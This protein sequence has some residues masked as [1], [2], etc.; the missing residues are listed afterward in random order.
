MTTL[1]TLPCVKSILSKTSA[2]V[3]FKE[4]IPQDEHFQYLTSLFSTS[5]FLS[6]HSYSV[7][8]PFVEYH[9][10]T[11]RRVVIPRLKAE[12]LS[13]DEVGREARETRM[14]CH[15]PHRRAG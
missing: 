6:N 11:A 8:C 4:R 3:N 7:P 2:A 9:V 13:D 15:R 14:G 12:F 10:A 1:H 5:T